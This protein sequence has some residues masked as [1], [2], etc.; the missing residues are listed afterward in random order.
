MQP[1]EID[2]IVSDAP[3]I[4]AALRALSDALAY[5]HRVVL[6]YG[7]F[8]HPHSFQRNDVI[9]GIS[10]L[11]ALLQLHLR[12]GGAATDPFAKEN[13]ELLEPFEVDADDFIREASSRRDPRLLLYK[14]MRRAGIQTVWVCPIVGAG[15]TGHGVLNHF[16]LAK[17]AEPAFPIERLLAMTHQVHTSFKRHGFFA[18]YLKIKPDEV[19]VLR[20]A[21]QGKSGQDIAEKLGVTPRTVENRLQR[22]RKKL[23]AAN[24]TEAVY[25]ANAYGVI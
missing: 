3:S 8:V 16:H 18:K 1:Q 20:F 19:E 6:F 2:R 15:I 17:Y 7:Y 11:N 21:A 5:P 9:A 4:P 10:H 14:A 13:V 22:A 23:R 12:F 25:K 24:G